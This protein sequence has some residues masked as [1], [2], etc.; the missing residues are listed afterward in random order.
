ME[1]GNT[2]VVIEHT[3]DIIKIADYIIDIGH[4]GGKGGRKIVAKGTPE[5]VAKEKKSFTAPFLA[6]ELDQK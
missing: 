3:L 2:L 5:Q 4:E 1:K 6:I